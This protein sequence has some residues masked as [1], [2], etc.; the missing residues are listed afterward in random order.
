MKVSRFN[1]LHLI[2]LII[3]AFLICGFQTTV[4]YQLFGAIPAPL[5]WLNLVLYLFLYRK[6]LES[7]ALVYFLAIIFSA[8]SSATL[9]QLWLAMLIMGLLTNVLKKRIFWPGMR[10]F[11]IAS[12]YATITYQVVSPA[13]GWMADDRVIM[14]SLLTSVAELILTPLA[15]APIYLILNFTDKW[16]NKDPLPESGGLEA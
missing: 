8:F 12:F 3:L 5:L 1:F 2:C 16:T 4:W 10:Y 7:L 14:N 6:P 9:G 13:I 15:A 11:M